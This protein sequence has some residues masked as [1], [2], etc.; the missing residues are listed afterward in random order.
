MMESPLIRIHRWLPLGG[1]FR[2]V[3][4]PNVHHANAM[5]CNAT[6]SFNV[7]YIN[8]KCIVLARPGK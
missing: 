2:P 6:P 7:L 1:V 4:A 5:Q 8:S 3:G